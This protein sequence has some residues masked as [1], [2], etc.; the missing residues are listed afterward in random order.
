MCITESV[1]KDNGEGELPFLYFFL[2]R[3]GQNTVIMNEA[4]ARSQ[5]LRITEQQDR[6]SQDF[7]TR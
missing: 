2:L 7:D 4:F 6:S 3:A 5:V 1:R